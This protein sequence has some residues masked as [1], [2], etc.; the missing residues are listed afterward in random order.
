LLARPSGQSPNICL[1]LTL[2]LFHQNALL[3]STAHKV[4]GGFDRI[5]LLAVVSGKRHGFAVHA[6]VTIASSVRRCPAR[7]SARMSVLRIFLPLPESEVARQAACI[8]KY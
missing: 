8:T 6:D 7:L 2:H 3:C 5:Q 1:A 4:Q